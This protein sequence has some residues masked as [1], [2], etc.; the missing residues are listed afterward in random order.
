[1]KKIVYLEKLRNAATFAVVLLHI[2]MTMNNNY[3][4]TEIGLTNYIV[5][6][7]IWI[8]VKWAVPCFLMISGALLLNKKD[9][10]VDKIVKYILRMFFVLLSFG[11]V[12]AMMEIFFNKRTLTVKSV[13]LSIYY[14]LSG[15]SWDHLWYIYTLIALYI[16]TIPLKVFID[17][18]E[19][20]N[21]DIFV[22]V[23]VIGN[24]IIPSI[25]S[26]F[27]LNIKNIMIITEF[28]TYYI[29]GYWLSNLKFENKMKNSAFAFGKGYLC[30]TIL[31]MMIEISGLVLNGISPDISVSTG[32]ILVLMQSVCVFLFFKTFFENKKMNL[33]DNVISMN[34]FAIYLVHPFYINLLYKLFKITP[35]STNICVGITICFVFIFTISLLSSYIL[36]VIPGIRDII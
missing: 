16:I 35:I 21:I 15:Q 10:T 18:T 33:I 25:N 36:R 22:A 5:F 12:F 20:K 19:K 28:P 29:L 23:L 3:T 9:I 6:S 7:N 1:M 14:V 32:N 17:N 2:A 11:T 34:S 13:F 26:I 31:M 30:S 8:V 4:P 24:F 27:G